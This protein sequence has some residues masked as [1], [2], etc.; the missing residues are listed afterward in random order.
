M[1]RVN[2]PAT[3]EIREIKGKK[4]HLVINSDFG[5]T[6]CR[7]LYKKIESEKIDSRLVWEDPNFC[8]TCIKKLITLSNFRGPYSKQSRHGWSSLWAVVVIE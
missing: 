7:L 8:T 4:K 1:N 5:Y 3:L 2:I 6:G